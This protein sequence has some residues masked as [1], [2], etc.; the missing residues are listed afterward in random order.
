MIDDAVDRVG[1]AVVVEFELQLLVEVVGDFAVDALV[2]RGGLLRIV[3]AVH[4]PTSD[5]CGLT[6]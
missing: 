4:E 6:V 1:D 5:R 3:L 2:E